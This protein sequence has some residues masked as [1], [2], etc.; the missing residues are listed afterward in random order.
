MIENDEG[1]FL[2]RGDLCECGLVSDRLRV[3]QFTK[4]GRRLLDGVAKEE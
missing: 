1:R 3:V 4:G 2:R